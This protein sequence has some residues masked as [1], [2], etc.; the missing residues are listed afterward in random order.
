MELACTLHF[1]G[2]DYPK[3]VK[4][5]AAAGFNAYEISPWLPRRLTG[6][7]IGRLGRLL[8]SNG[9]EFSGFT[10]IYPP[11]MILA[12]PSPYVRRKSILYTNQLVEFV[13]L[14]GGRSIGWGSPRARQIP[15]GVP[16]E[17]GYRRLIK[18]LKASGTLAEE[19][20][21]RI[22]IEPV[23]RFE[24]SNIHTVREALTLAR[25]VNRKNVGIVYDSHHASFEETSFTR[26]IF[27]AGKR[28]MAVHVSDCNRKI[29]GKGHIDFEPIF[30]ALRK[31]GY[32]EY[33][34]LEAIF[35]RNLR[36]ELTTA[37]K[38]LE[39]MI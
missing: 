13:Q 11:E 9:L 29:P 6:S 28:I 20:N 23:N 2:V 3:G 10:A 5:V 27:L 30:D 4:L 12:S 25:S 18:L 22:A 39:R 37:R 7:D 16:A 1:A 34:T 38:R 8:R 24:S 36:R 26:P 32:D 21:V 15:N 31:V 33:V 35:E 19:R 14:L 17:V